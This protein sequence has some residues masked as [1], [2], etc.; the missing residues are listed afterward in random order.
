MAAS[1][2]HGTPFSSAATGGPCSVSGERGEAGT[3]T[4]DGVHY[5]DGWPKDSI[6]SQAIEYLVG[7]RVNICGIAVGVELIRP[8]VC[9]RGLSPK[10]FWKDVQVFVQIGVYYGSLK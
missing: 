2:T 10:Y 3:T 1:G 5:V 4:R 9:G 6:A 7:L 8:N